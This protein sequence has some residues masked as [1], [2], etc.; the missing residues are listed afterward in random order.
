VH[1]IK[2]SE[3]LP[4]QMGASS[5]IGSGDI[6]H[7]A[8]AQRLKAHGD[9]TGNMAIKYPMVGRLPDQWNKEAMLAFL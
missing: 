6:Q 8:H 5:K 2:M 4:K 1:K 9:F 7:A 3:L